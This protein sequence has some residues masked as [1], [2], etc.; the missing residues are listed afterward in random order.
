MGTLQAPAAFPD[1]PRAWK[2][3]VMLPHPDPADLESHS[4]V[5]KSKVV[6]A[7]EEVGTPPVAITGITG[8]KKL[9]SAPP[10]MDS[11]SGG[12]KNSLCSCLASQCRNFSWKGNHCRAIH[13]SAVPSQPCCCCFGAPSQQFHDLEQ[14]GMVRTWR[15][16]SMRFLSC[17]DPSGVLGNAQLSCNSTKHPHS[18]PWRNTERVS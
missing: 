14:P 3:P 8:I 6:L 7:P 15:K 10:G 9:S 12:I 4:K 2:F 1:P 11:L 13:P 18:S 5:A 17:L 16:C